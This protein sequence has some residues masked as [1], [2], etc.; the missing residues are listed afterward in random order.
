MFFYQITLFGL[1]QRG[2]PYL[3]IA[4]IC[5]FVAIRAMI[6]SRGSY[7]VPELFPGISVATWKK[8]EF[9]VVYAITAIFPLYIY[10]LFPAHASKR[11]L[12]FFVA[13]GII[14][15]AVVVVT[16]YHIYGQLLNVFHI[17]LIGGFIFS[18]QIISRAWRAGNPDA[19]M[20][21]YGIMA[22]FPFIF[23]EIVKNSRTINVSFSFPYLVEIGVLIFLLFQAYLLANQFAKPTEIWKALMLIWK[24]K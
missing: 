4:L 9:L 1:F 21:L 7:L 22:S 14:L 24:Q 18:V 5:L 8:V 15:C 2:K 19:R 13:V 12:R 23:L 6:T 11:I 3:Y 20:I 16:T 10:S 17:A